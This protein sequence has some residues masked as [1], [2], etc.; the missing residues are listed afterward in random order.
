MRCRVSI[1]RLDKILSAAGF[2]T[3]SEC[4]ALARKGLITVN[5]ITVRRADAKTDTS[6]EISVNGEI[7]E[8]HRRT[9]CIMNKPSGFVTSAKDD[10]SRTVMEL[11]PE[12]FLRQ[13]VVPV[14]RLDKD[15][16]GLLVFTNDGDLNHRLTSPNMGVLKIYR[17]EHEN[18]IT[19]EAVV[20]ARSGIVLKDGTLCRSA[21]I[22]RLSDGIST[23]SIRE[24]MYHQVK[25]MFAALGCRVKY[26]K[27]ICIG[28]LPLG[29]LEQGQTRG[30]DDSEIA[31][32]FEL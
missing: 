7:V 22:T 18:S 11:L 16:E 32:L 30:L 9:V 3:R 8:P 31:A 6:A 17:V 27:R 14:G 25:R 23:I 10:R 26:L 19:D 29:S 2:C 1:E 12:F 24:G 15:A 5:G 20:R 21:E 28:K 13:K 4:S